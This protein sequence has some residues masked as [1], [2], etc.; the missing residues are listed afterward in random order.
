MQTGWLV[1]CGV[2]A[3]GGGGDVTTEPDDADG[4]PHPHDDARRDDALE[5]TTHVD[6]DAEA[7]SHPECWR[8]DEC[9]TGGAQS[10]FVG[11][12]RD[13]ACLAVIRSGRCRFDVG[14]DGVCV[15]GHCVGGLPYFA[16]D[17]RPVVPS[18]A[19]CECREDTW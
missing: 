19:A 11:L 4:A 9:P 17:E 5:V 3:C 18:A 15:G 14:L 8:D 7:G 10:C 2:L 6:V 16:A 12:C 1:T 13:G